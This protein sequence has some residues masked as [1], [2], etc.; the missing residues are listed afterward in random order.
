[1]WSKKKPRLKSRFFD[2]RYIYIIF[3]EINPL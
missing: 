2:L 1:L 3:V